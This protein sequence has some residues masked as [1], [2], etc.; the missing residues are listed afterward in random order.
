MK[1]MSQDTS[2][3]AKTKKSTITKARISYQGELGA[4]SHVACLERFPELESVPCA[5]FEDAVQAVKSGDCTYAM[6]PIENTL[7]GRVADVHHLLPGAGL[8]IVGEHF[9]PIRFQADQR[10]RLVSLRDERE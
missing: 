2:P 9:L 8:F 7:A 3:A 6:I 1:R 10:S 4:N 5:T